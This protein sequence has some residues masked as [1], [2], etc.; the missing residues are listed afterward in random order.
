MR[1]AFHV[2][3]PLQPLPLLLLPLAVVLAAVPSYT[4]THRLAQTHTKRLLLSKLRG[5]RQVKQW[6]YKAATTT[7]TTTTALQ[8][9]TIQL[10]VKRARLAPMLH[11]NSSLCCAKEKALE[12]P[13]NIPTLSRSLSLFRI[14]SNAHIYTQNNM[15]ILLSRYTYYFHSLPISLIFS[16]IL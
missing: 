10:S 15:A 11:T 1:L 7:T 8:H 9:T 3:F 4:H 13:T 2:L 5:S 6:Y 16:Y 12:L 14:H